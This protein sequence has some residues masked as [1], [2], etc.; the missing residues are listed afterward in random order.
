M[1]FWQRKLV[2]LL[3]T[4]FLIAYKNSSDVHHESAIKIMKDI[5]L[6]EY[7]LA[8]VSDYIIDES[9]SVLLSKMKNFELARS[10]GKELISSFE[11]LFMNQELF[12]ISWRIFSEQNKTALSLTDCSLLALMCEKGVSHLAT[13]DKRFIGVNGIQVIDAVRVG[14]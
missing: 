13:F 2:I 8:F 4:S 11:V 14:G 6:G 3:D 9:I 1:I 10:F 12:E 5:S 7:G